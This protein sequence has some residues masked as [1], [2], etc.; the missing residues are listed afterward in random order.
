[1]DRNQTALEL[2][3]VLDRLAE[4]TSCE[5]TAQMARDLRPTADLRRVTKRLNETDDA[6][7]LMARFGA[8]SF[9]AVKNVQSTVRRAE[10]GAALSMRELLDI[11]ELLRVFRGVTEWHGR[12]G[13]VGTSLDDRFS[14]VIPNKYLEEK[15]STAILSEDTVADNASPTLADIRRKI[16]SAS[17][18]LRD[19]LDSMIRSAAYQKALQDPIVTI[20]DGRFVVPV[21]AEHRG[22]IAGLVHDTSASGATVFIEPMAVVDANNEIRLLQSQ[23]ETEIERILA[24]LSAD[25]GAFAGSICSGY[26]RLLELDL[27]F[28]KAALAYDMKATRP[29]LTEDGHILLRHARHPLI[30]R[31]KVVPVDVELGGDFDTLVVTGPNTG[32]KT[33]TLKT[34]GLLTLMTMCGLL[35]PVDDGSIISTFDH[36]LVDI[37]DEQSIEQSLS[38][39]SAHMKNL[40]AILKATDDRSLVLVDELGAGTDPVEGAAL[41]IAILERLREK[42]ARVAATTHY[43]ELKAYAVATAGVENGSCEFDVKTLKPTY[44]LLVGV[45]GRSNAFA[46]SERL[47]MDADLVERA[48]SLVSGDDRRM[49]EVVVRLDERRQALETEL[50]EARETRS[51]AEKAAAAAKVRVGELETARQAEL[52]TAREKA[53]QIVERARLDAERLIEELDRLRKQKNK[54]GFADAA[55]DAKSRLRAELRRMEQELDPVDA[56]TAEEYTLPRPLKAGDTVRLSD[57]GKQ[58][59]VVTPPDK[60]GMTEVLVGIV[61]TRVPTETLRLCE[62]GETAPTAKK[63]RAAARRTEQAGGAESGVARRLRDVHTE[64]DLRG[65]AADEGLLE[66]DRFI[67]GAVMSGLS[68]VT[69]IHGKGTGILRAAVQKHLKKHPSVKSFRLGAYGE[70][71]DGVTVV[72]LK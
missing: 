3:K 72:E 66:L 35:P 20:R 4:K 8:P 37:G 65:M 56:K 53:R 64:V 54:A 21:K 60:S 13:G 1:M 5:D 11:A 40:I 45:P 46:I 29:T 57:L 10:A 51:S 69:V 28:A 44:R 59:T 70:G 47:G 24:E 50:A 36:V 16:R 25:A 61:R 55:A 22:E 9:G 30:D 32:G 58:G 34:L 38:T 19:H 31:Q 68:A 6:M 14:G 33:V 15:I 48:R 26:K 7:G 49:E 18:R 17:T 23:E 12:C 41:A 63:P 71:E 42:G 27:I 43:A 52:E 67:D 2:N 62:A 39:F